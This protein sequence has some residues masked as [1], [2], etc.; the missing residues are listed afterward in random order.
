MKS[1]TGQ[2]VKLFIVTPKGERIEMKNESDLLE[3]P[4]GINN[5]LFRVPA[6]HRLKA[7]GL[8][9][10]IFIKKNLFNQRYDER[11]NFM[12]LVFD[13]DHIEA[14][15]DGRKLVLPF[16]GDLWFMLFHQIFVKNQYDLNDANTKGKVF[17]DAGAN[18][19]AFSIFAA[20]MGARKVYAFEPVK[21]TFDALKTNIEACGLQDVIIP[22]NKGLGKENFTAKIKAD[23]SGDGG[24]SIGDEGRGPRDFEY[25]NEQDAQIVTLDSFLN[26]EKVDLIKLDTEGYETNIFLGASKTIIAY[27]PILDFSAYHHADDKTKLPQVID[28]IRSGYKCKLNSYYEEVFYCEEAI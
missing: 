6:K 16:G 14:E 22:V 21:G 15:F 3:K 17:V 7:F 8:L 27:A 13:I 26:G 28:G 23:Y 2:E 11:H 19:G 4:G 20:C 5:N 25:K 10:T 18:L 24:A 12:N 9:A 1:R